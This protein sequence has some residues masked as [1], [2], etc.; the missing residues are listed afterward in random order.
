MQDAP[1]T[2]RLVLWPSLLTLVLSCVR[3]AG[4]VL[5]WLPATSGG[6]L[7]PLG[8]GWGMLVF[9]GWFGWRLARGGSAPRVA[10]AWAWAWPLVAL[11]TIVATVVLMFGPL[12]EA[13]PSEA[14]FVL[15]RGGV[16]TIAAVALAGATTMFMVWP[17]LA[18]TL[19]VYGLLARATVVAMTWLAKTNAWN[20]HYTKFG[21]SGFE[22]DLEDTLVGASLAQFGVWVPLTIVAGTLAGVCCAGRRR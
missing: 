7:H 6:A 20:T 19:L 2:L 12:R 13:A 18:W 9:G 21:P 15:L 17:R 14:N 22:R 3:L 10:R 1:P 8:I 11:S 5:G 16:L 4:E